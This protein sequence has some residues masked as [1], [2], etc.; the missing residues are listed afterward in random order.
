MKIA[1]PSMDDRGL[2]ARVA[3]HFGQAS[4][5]TIVD[6][7]TDEVTVQANSGHHQGGQQTPAS[8]IAEKGARVVLC[9]GLGQRAVRF[10]SEAGIEVFMGAEG[11]VQETMDTHRQGKLPAASEAAACPGHHSDKEK[12]MPLARSTGMDPPSSKLRVSKHEG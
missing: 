1:I 2:Q 4:F 10:F 5:F 12:P 8:A 11:T 6:T 9:S 7:D 3:D